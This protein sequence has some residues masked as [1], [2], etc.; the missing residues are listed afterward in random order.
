MA[1]DVV[2]RCNGRCTCGANEA[3]PTCHFRSYQTQ[4]IST[5]SRETINTKDCKET[6]ELDKRKKKGAIP[7]KLVKQLWECLRENTGT[8]LTAVYSS[9]A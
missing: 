4:L 8:F 5:G 6:K 9:F 1:V 2:G 3:H 7:F